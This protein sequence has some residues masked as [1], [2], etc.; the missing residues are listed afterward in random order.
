MGDIIVQLRFGLGELRDLGSG[1]LDV[2]IRK[3]RLRREED[4]SDIDSRLE[5][6]RGDAL[7]GEGDG[8]RDGGGGSA[9][10]SSLDSFAGDICGCI[11]S[12]GSRRWEA[13][14]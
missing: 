8:G 9:V 14:N 5:D 13:E 4:T 10:D 12:K 3:V 1:V 6:V 7:E 2:V 11:M